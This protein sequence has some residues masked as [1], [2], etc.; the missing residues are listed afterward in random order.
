MKIFIIFLLFV[1]P[2]KTLACK[3]G[4]SGDP[5]SSS[6]EIVYAK[7]LSTKLIEP[8]DSASYVLV[9]YDIVESFKKM[10]GSVNTV[11]ESLGTCS[12]GLR[13]GASY[14]LFIDE[15]RYIS[16]CDG[17]KYVLIW[18]EWGKKILNDLRSYTKSK[19]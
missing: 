17:S 8:K 11:K 7:V 1:L 14:V 18:T 5:Y 16:K 2:L 9:E 15:T 13:A 12:L 6:K 4:E 3:C 10:D 19:K